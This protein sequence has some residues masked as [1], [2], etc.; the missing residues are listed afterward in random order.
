MKALITGV[1]GQDG[2]YLSEL[3]LDKGYEV[4]GVHRRSSTKNLWRIDKILRA[5]DPSFKLVEGDVSDYISMSN[6]KKKK[7][8]DEIYNLAAQSHVHTSFEQPFYTTQVNYFGCL[9]ILEIVKNSGLDCK[10]YQAS[11]SE[12]FGSNIN[13]DYQDVFVTIDS[14]SDYGKMLTNLYNNVYQDENTPFSP[15]SPYAISKLAAHNAIRLYRDSYKL[16]CCAR[17]LFN[18]ESPR[19]GDEFVTKKI[20]NYVRKIMTNTRGLCSVHGSTK[21]ELGNLQAKRDW[22]YAP[23]YCNAMWLMLQEKEMDDYVIATGETHTIQDFLE[24]AFGSQGFDWRQFVVVKDNLKRP[25]E[26]SF[27]RGVADK[28]KKKLGWQPEITFKKLV[29]IMLFG[30]YY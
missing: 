26:V 23:E 12:M 14:N 18:H 24:E 13:T 15:N 28:A 8:P 11:R 25:C 7:K 20:A 2:S 5:S 29:H 10:I 27:L 19:R 6:I 21:L 9:N 17:I 1:T 22:G 30:G 16:K 4:I 3:L